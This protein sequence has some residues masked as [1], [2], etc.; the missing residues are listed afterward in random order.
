MKACYNLHVVQI[1]ARLSCGL[2]RRER[3]RLVREYQSHPD[4]QREFA[5]NLGH[6]I[7]VLEEAKL[8]GV[9]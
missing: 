3:E 9:R 2:S 6:V 4:A 8:Y 5:P 1:L 7:Q